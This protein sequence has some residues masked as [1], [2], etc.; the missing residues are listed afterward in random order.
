MFIQ[1]MRCFVLI[2][3]LEERFDHRTKDS[4]QTYSEV[5][6][7]R[8]P[9]FELLWKVLKIFETSSHGLKKF[10]PRYW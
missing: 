3:G 10:R 6:V 7:A 4:Q 5:I 1:R 2:H 9:L 8:H